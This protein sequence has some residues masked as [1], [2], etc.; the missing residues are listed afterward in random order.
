MLLFVHF[1]ESWMTI[2]Q[3]QA[4]L[5]SVLPRGALGTALDG[6]FVFFGSIASSI[7]TRLA[8]LRAR[9]EFGA[10]AAS[11]RPLDRSQHSSGPDLHR[12]AATAAMI[13]RLP[14]LAAVLSLAAE[15]LQAPSNAH[16]AITGPPPLAK[17]I[18]AKCVEA[19]AR[20]SIVPDASS[21]QAVRDVLGNK[22]PVTHVC[23]GG[24]NSCAF[25][26]VAAPLLIIVYRVDTLRN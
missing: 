11:A 22:P 15:G 24:S 3:A 5:A 6:Y 17:A 1:A 23:D 18:G 20:F 9:L 10:R 12:C 14:C 16:V 7:H 26:G 25:D 21:R 19:G 8:G 4:L 13:L 2:A